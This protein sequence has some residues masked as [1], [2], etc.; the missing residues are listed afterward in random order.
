LFGTSHL[1]QKVL[2]CGTRAEHQIRYPQRGRN[3]SSFTGN[4]NGVQTVICVLGERRALHLIF[5]T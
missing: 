1:P 5:L 4:R 2:W 3:E